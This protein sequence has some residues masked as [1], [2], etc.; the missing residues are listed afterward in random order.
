MQLG[1][2]MTLAM[3]DLGIIAVLNSILAMTVSKKD[4]DFFYEKH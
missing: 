2:E 1:E 3:V 4:D